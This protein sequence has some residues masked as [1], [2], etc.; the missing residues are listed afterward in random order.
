MRR[1]TKP[2][3]MSQEEKLVKRRPS[4]SERRNRWVVEYGERI[5]L[6]SIQEELEEQLIRADA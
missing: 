1:P 2:G 5:H 3:R 6:D 4:G